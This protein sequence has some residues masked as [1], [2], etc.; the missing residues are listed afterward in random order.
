MMLNVG[1]FSGRWALGLQ[2]AFFYCQVLLAVSVAVWSGAASASGSLRCGSYLVSVGD[3][4]D[5]VKARC[6]PPSYRYDT[7]SGV[8]WIYN[9]GPSRFLER[10]R[11]LNG[12][13]ADISSHG[14][15]FS[16]SSDK[17]A[18]PPYPQSEINMPPYPFPYQYEGPLYP[19]Y[20]PF[21]GSERRKTM[22]KRH[23]DRMRNESQNRELNELN[24]TRRKPFADKQQ[25]DRR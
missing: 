25:K 24:E 15:G 17:Q 13:L 19:Q 9:F 1:Q 14:Y 2:S 4:A 3:P 5:M 12:R 18:T 10:L 16:G 22:R 21:R 8:I 20:I 7:A 6:G 23:H 11:F